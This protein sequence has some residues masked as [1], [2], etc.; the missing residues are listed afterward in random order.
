MPMQPLSVLVPAKS[1]GTT[2]N[3]KVSARSSLFPFAYAPG[4]VLATH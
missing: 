4:T 1:V 3:W 2:K